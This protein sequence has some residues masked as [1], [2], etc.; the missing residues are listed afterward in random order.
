MKKLS[1][2]AVVGFVKVVYAVQNRSKTNRLLD[3]L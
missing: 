2:F 1:P 3:Y